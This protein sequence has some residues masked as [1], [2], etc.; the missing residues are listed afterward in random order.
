MEIAVKTDKSSAMSRREREKQIR[1]REIISAA[2]KVFCLNGYEASSMDEIAREAQFTKRT[3]YQYFENKEELYFAVVLEGYRLLLSKLTSQRKDEKTGYEKLE[4]AIGCYYDFYRE[5]PEIFR[6]M[7]YWGHVGRKSEGEGRYK[8][9]GEGRYKGELIRF[10]NSMFQR[11]AEV[12]E[13]GKADGSIQTETDAQ[14]AAY[15][16]VLLMTGFFHQLSATGGNFT[17]CDSLDQE[18]FSRFTI[19]MVIKTLKRNKSVMTTR[20]G[21]V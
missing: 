12:I 15:S 18:E 13:E 17:G 7:N 4:R 9:E 2:E 5:S 6:L 19:D 21:T 20:K 10:I 3:L 11:V 16:L 14:K 1:E 8:G